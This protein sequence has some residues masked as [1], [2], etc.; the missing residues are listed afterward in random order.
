MARVK[1]S[2]VSDI[3][4]IE[5]AAAHKARELFEEVEWTVEEEPQVGAMRPDL[6]V[7]SPNGATYVVEV[8]A[9]QGSAHFGS[10]AQVATFIEEYQD[11]RAVEDVR[12]LLVTNMATQEN[13]LE[14]ARSLG[15]Q[16]VPVRGGP[17]EMAQELFD[18]IQ[19]GELEK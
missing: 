5:R 16:V 7:Q 6:V 8:K 9:G 10:V 15:I 4:E 14:A 11:V 13:I 18:Q 2:S 3:N 1:P 12:G 19:R 17:G